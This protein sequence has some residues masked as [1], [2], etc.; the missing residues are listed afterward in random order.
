MIL[1]PSRMGICRRM[2]GRLQKSCR[3]ATMSL[4]RPRGS[5]MRLMKRMQGVPDAS[6]MR[7]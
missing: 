3:A 5:S 1:S 4:M 6:I 7:K 2:S